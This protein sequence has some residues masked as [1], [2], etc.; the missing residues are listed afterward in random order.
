MGS[1]FGLVAN[2]LKLKTKLWKGSRNG[3]I[4][5]IRVGEKWLKCSD[6]IHKFS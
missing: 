3:I 1:A 5:E 6:E 2:A 4:A